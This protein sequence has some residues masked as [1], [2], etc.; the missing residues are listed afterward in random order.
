MSK[1]LGGGIFLTRALRKWA[2]GLY[3]PPRAAAADRC[4]AA[5]AADATSSARRRRRP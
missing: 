1:N 2:L 5:A 4:V 3:T